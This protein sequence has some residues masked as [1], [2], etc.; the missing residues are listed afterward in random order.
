MLKN[1]FLIRSSP[2]GELLILTL[3]FDRTGGLK[4]GLFRDF[5]AAWLESVYV[6]PP[7]RQRNAWGV[8]FRFLRLRFR[9]F[10]ACLR[11]A[12]AFALALR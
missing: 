11:L 7:G 3:Y 9:D 6:S 8:H 4:Q 1:I 2:S 10:S 5:A 12:L